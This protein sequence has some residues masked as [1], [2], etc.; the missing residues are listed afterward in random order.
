MCIGFSPSGRTQMV[1]TKAQNVRP[2]ELSDDHRR[3]WSEEGS[4]VGAEGYGELGTEGSRG[5]GGGGRVEMGTRKDQDTRMAMTPTEY[6]NEEYRDLNTPQMIDDS[7]TKS[8]SMDTIDILMDCPP[9][10]GYY[11]RREEYLTKHGWPSPPST[12]NTSLPRSPFPGLT[13]EQVYSGYANSWDVEQN[14]LWRRAL[15]DPERQYVG[16]AML[17]LE[18]EI[19]AEPGLEPKRNLFARTVEAVCRK[20]RGLLRH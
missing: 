12:P 2:A 18:A 11:M 5:V 10:V 17:E 16:D 13:V 4:G 15:R 6:T 19:D 3:K 14:W 8:S 20:F 7:L 9:L 1:C